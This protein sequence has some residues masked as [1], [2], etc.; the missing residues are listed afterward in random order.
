MKKFCISQEVSVERLIWALVRT[1]S[2][3]F[4]LS[5][6]VSA[7]WWKSSDITD[8]VSPEKHHIWRLKRYHE[9]TRPEVG[10]KHGTQNSEKVFNQIKIQYTG[11]QSRQANI[12]QNSHAEAVG[13]HGQKSGNQK[14]LLELKEK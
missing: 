13:E 6:I 2:A 3:A 14:E 9:D 5:W 8:C 4:W 1:Q 11:D 7:A 12:T 10:P